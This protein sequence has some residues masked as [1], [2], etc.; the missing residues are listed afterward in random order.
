MNEAVKDT[1]IKVRKNPKSAYIFCY[2]NGEQVRDIRKSFW[3]ALKKSG[4]KDFRFHDLRHSAAGHLVM[5]GTDR[6]HAVDFLGR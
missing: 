4:I 3:T 5:A 2:K 6:K 1:L